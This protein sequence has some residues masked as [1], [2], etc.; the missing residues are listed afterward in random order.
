MSET[1]NKYEKKEDQSYFLVAVAFQY[2]EF[3]AKNVLCGLSLF[4]VYLFFLLV[5]IITST[6][7]KTLSIFLLLSFFK[8]STDFFLQLFLRF[9]ILLLFIHFILSIFILSSNNN[10]IAFCPILLFISYVGGG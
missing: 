3:F 2:N 10:S 4:D 8:I 9:L 7:E 5:A 6:A 1:I